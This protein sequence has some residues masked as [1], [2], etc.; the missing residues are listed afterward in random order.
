MSRGWPW[1][2]MVA[3]A[4]PARVLGPLDGW[5]LNG[6]EEALLIGLVVP[7]LLWFDRRPFTH[8][9]L[10]IAVI[11]LLSAKL[12]TYAVAPQGLCARFSTTAPFIGETHTIPIVEPEGWLRSWDVR[13]DWRDATPACTAI[14]DRGYAST[15]EFPA[16]FVNLVNAIR[17][18][19]NDVSMAVSG[20][21]SVRENG[22]FAIPV[23]DGSEI[24]GAIGSVAVD[25]RL[26]PITAALEAG[27]HPIALTGTLRGDNWQ[28]A[29]TWNGGDA[30]QSTR[31]TR[32][33]NGPL[34]RLATPLSIAITLL[35]AA[36][37]A[38]WLLLAL[39]SWRN[40]VP[41]LAWSFT[42]SVILGFT[43]TLQGANRFGALLL[44]AAVAVPVSVERRNLR[45]AFL[46]VGVPWLA[47]F[48]VHA[49]PT[50]GLVTS[51][52]HDDW[53]AYQVAAYRIYMHGY[54]LEGGNLA[55]DYQPLYR[56][57]AGAIHMVFGD[58][59]AGEIF[60]DAGWLLAG[61]LVTF[62]LV[63]SAAGFTWAIGA[64]AAVLATFAAGTT[65]HF[66]GR[67]L[68][69]IAAAGFGF[70]AAFF[71]LR[72][73]L[74]RVRSLLAAGALAGLMFYTRLNFLLAGAS[75]VALLLPTRTPSALAALTGAV[76][77]LRWRLAV[78]YAAVMC[79]AVGLFMTRTWWYTGQ[80]SV[81]YGTSLK[82][83]D[84]GLRLDTLANVE[85]W[86]RVRH[87]LASLLLMNEPPQFDPRA[88][89]VVLGAIAVIMAALQ[90]PV[91]RRIPASLTLVTLGM[92]ASALFVHTHNY[93]GRMT[94]PL[95][96]FACAAAVIGARLVTH[97]AASRR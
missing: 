21:V 57:I 59:S 81:L 20:Y 2:A 96:P 70:V 92:C 87:S 12:A 45:A 16:W 10:R 41:L 83:N 76:G 30:W 58:S 77:R 7:A 89:F 44:A 84:L 74:G 36:I 33:S 91:L 94:I 78:I 24:S 37:V 95:V 42:A 3:M 43:A 5:P 4:W 68:S 65:W 1:L 38:A 48:A 73:R 15:G 69:E 47:F 63:K 64:A 11:A 93:P 28:L 60:A 56:W 88:L 22:T 79:L 46:M 35:T 72:A 13:A 26:Q 61:A 71:V 23:S 8:V 6:R 32:S 97:H 55:F 67:G 19:A 27:T 85:V 25:S 39:A 86:R 50:I 62:A 80:F 31:F 17:P 40:E 9:L 52:S 29:P 90:V 49:V 54:W 18:A 53:L 34:D 14:L 66:I 75:L 82:N 51:Y